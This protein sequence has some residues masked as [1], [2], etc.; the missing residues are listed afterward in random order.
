M[1]R[2][3]NNMGNAHGLSNFVA[4][5]LIS[6]WANFRYHHSLSNRFRVSVVNG[7]VYSFIEGN[8]FRICNNGWR[9]RSGKGVR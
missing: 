7:T 6:L 2:L 3:S 1:I 9:K 4:I 5:P 8:L